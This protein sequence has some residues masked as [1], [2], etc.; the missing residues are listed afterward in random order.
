MLEQRPKNPM[1]FENKRE[2]GQLSFCVDVL[3][4]SHFDCVLVV[5]VFVLFSPWNV[6]GGENKM[7]N[8][9]GWFRYD[10]TDYD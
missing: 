1:A 10:S 9:V 6:Q 3:L 5:F 7:D 4:L 8:M 2:D